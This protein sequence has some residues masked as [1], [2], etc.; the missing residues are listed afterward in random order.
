MAK[1][2]DTPYPFPKFEDFINE[3]QW[4]K[5]FEESERALEAIPVERLFSWGV[6]DGHAYYYV[7][8]FSP[9]VLQ[10][11][12]YLDSYSL[13][14][15]HIRGLRREDVDGVINVNIALNK[16]FRKNTNKNKI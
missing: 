6:A 12:P 16:L 10:F 14:I 5:Y 4:N 15:A 11:V 2:L 1:L 8:S 13:P 3:E 7:V 9:L